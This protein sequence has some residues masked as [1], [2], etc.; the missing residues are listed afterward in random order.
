M[1]RPIKPEWLLR[2]ADVL[3]GRSGGQ[4]QPINADL[5]RAVSAAYYALFHHLALLAADQ[6]LP[7]GTQQ[8]RWRFTRHMQ[9]TA[10]LRVCEWTLGKAPPLRYRQL[11][12]PLGNDPRLVD[13]AIAFQALQQERHSADYDHEAS[14]TKPQVLNLI[15]LARD[16]IQKADSLVGRNILQVFLLHMAITSKMPGT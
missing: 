1:Q 8:D 12:A 7:N 15:D 6:L 2:Q 5:R 4:G 10:M 16:A 13:V 11:F 9:H 14:Y 3:A